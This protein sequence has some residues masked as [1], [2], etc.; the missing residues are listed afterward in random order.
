[1]TPVNV[2]V[3]VTYKAKMRPSPTY[4]IELCLYYG[5]IESDLAGTSLCKQVRRNVLDSDVVHCIMVGVETKQI[6]AVSAGLPPSLTPVPQWRTRY[7]SIPA[8]IR[9]MIADSDRRTV[10]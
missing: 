10:A 5:V 2:S 3:E 9:C 1:M 7:D 6:P 4:N 8:N